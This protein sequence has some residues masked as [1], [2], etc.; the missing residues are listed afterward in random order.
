MIWGTQTAPP[1]GQARIVLYDLPTG[2]LLSPGQLQHVNLGGRDRPLRPTPRITPEG[3]VNASKPGQAATIQPTYIVG[4]SYRD[5]AVSR[6]E[7]TY[8]WSYK[9][10]QEIWDRWFASGIPATLTAAEL[11]AGELPNPRMRPLETQKLAA[12]KNIDKA[13]ANLIVEGMFNLNSTSV[14]A[15][16]ALLG[17]TA[18]GSSPVA[19]PTETSLTFDPASGT[20][21]AAR[22]ARTL[23]TNQVAGGGGMST[24]GGD[25]L[26]RWSGPVQLTDPQLNDLAKGIVQRIKDRTKVMGRPF[27]SLSEFI[28]RNTSKELGILQETFDQ[29]TLPTGT[30]GGTSSR[31]RPAEQ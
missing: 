18:N 29:K 17:S 28:N 21:I 4:N 26:S 6:T 22:Y 24:V 1:L 7:L 11:A 25:A 10:N 5:P 13:A 20:D 23:I 9:A 14:E 15:W 27:A 30:P 19:A 12:V 3:G 8:D 2:D 31:W 16:K